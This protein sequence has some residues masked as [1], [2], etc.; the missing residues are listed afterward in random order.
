MVI[1]IAQRSHFFGNN[2]GAKRTN[3]SKQN[4]DWLQINDDGQ[5]C[6][7]SDQRVHKLGQRIDHGK[8]TVVCFG[9]GS[10]ILG[11]EGRMVV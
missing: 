4:Q 11:I 10:G 9:E 8:G 6:G 1:V 2:H 3:K 7:Y 5:D